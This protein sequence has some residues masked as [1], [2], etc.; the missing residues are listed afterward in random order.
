MLGNLTCNQVWQLIVISSR[1]W[2]SATKL[3]LIVHTCVAFVQRPNLLYLDAN[4]NLKLLNK[5]ASI[6]LMRIYI[7]RLFMKVDEMHQKCI[8][9]IS[10][11]DS[12]NTT[13]F[14]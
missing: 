4:D 5:V 10:F 8:I 13:L 1:S 7:K 12:N 3:S 9:Y 14:H 6:E 2:Q 11:P